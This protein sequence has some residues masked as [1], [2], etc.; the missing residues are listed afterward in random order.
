MQ[1]T[2]HYSYAGGLALAGLFA[3]NG[4]MNYIDGVIELFYTLI[5]ALV[6]L[7]VPVVVLW[8]VFKLIKSL[9]R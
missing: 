5:Q 4:G 2:T 6:P 8:L 7:I 9:L 1:S 3:Y